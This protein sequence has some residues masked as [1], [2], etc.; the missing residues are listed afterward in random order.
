MT[1][2]E[3]SA[4][5]DRIVDVKVGV[6]GDFALDLYYSI[7]TETGERSIETELD[8]HWAS[9]PRASLGG[10]GNVVQNLVALGIQYIQV[11]GC[12]GNDLF[13]R[14]MRGLFNQAGVQTQNLL[15]PV[16]GWDTCVYTKPMRGDKEMNRIDFGIHNALLDDTVNELLAGLEQ[17][18]SDLDVVII[19]QQFANPLL[20]ASHIGRLNNLIERFP[21]VRFVVDMR[22]FG[23][24]VQGATLKVNTNELARFLAIEAP[25][26]PNLDWCLQQG[27]RLIKS[28]RGPLVITRGEQGI[29]YMDEDKFQVVDG[30]AL[31]VELDTVGAGDTVVAAWA[32]CTGA[33]AKPVQALDVA[34]LAAAVTVQKLR[35]TGTANPSEIMALH[36]IYYPHE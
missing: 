10:A 19:N 4:L 25:D 26:E 35:Q 5:F 21:N 31:Q 34:N 17:C 16:A 6:I 13:G 24:L 15:T 29:L 28:R 9:Q 22:H 2:P 30:I 7:Q 3:F 8:V 33:G 23:K 20:K 1:S 18:L 27:L 14:E 36:R 32:A 12:V 11:F